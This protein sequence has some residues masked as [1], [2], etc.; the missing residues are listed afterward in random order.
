MINQMVRKKSVPQ[1][2]ATAKPRPNRDILKLVIHQKPD[3]KRKSVEQLL[4][5]LRHGL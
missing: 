5:E 4:H 3:P 2:T 1:S